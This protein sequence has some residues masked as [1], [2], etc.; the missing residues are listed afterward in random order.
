MQEYFDKTSHYDYRDV[1]YTWIQ[2]VNLFFI[3][4]FFSNLLKNMRLYE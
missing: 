4:L 3:K 2:V 1:E